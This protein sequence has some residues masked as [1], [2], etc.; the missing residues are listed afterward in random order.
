MCETGHKSPDLL[1][2]LDEHQPQVL[3]VPLCLLFLRGS[4]YREKIKEFQEKERMFTSLVDLI[5][6]AIFLSITPQVKEGFNAI[7]R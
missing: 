5:T 2:L 3:S 1:L 4:F 7:T 6:I